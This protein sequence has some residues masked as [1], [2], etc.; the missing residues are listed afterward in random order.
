MAE[1]KI[2][3]VTPIT[4]ISDS[5]SF[6]VN[7]G[8]ALSQLAK[9]N[10]LQA[11]GG[12]SIERLWQNSDYTK[13]FAQQDISIDLSEYQFIIAFFRA[14]TNYSGT[15]G[16]LT[17]RGYES[18]AVLYAAGGTTVRTRTFYP[19][20]DKITIYGGYAGSTADNT[21]CIPVSIYGVKGVMI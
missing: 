7:A 21:A 16:V 2:T 8:N 6:F 13:E 20:A 3:E 18:R 10:V 11:I 19:T 9:Q 15:V 12:V 1:R 5:D 17:L 14:A 4:S